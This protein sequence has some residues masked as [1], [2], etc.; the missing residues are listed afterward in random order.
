MTFYG[1][2]ISNWPGTGLPD[3]DKFGRQVTGKELLAQ[4]IINHLFCAKGSYLQSPNFGIDLMSHVYRAE[5]EISTGALAL[6]ITTE[7]AQIERLDPDKTVCSVTFA[8]DTIKIRLQV[9]P[10]DGPEFTLVM[11]LSHVAKEIFLL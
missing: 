9:K 1:V 7:L 11:S 3:L 5:R 6:D 4:E 2:D 10:S 8:N